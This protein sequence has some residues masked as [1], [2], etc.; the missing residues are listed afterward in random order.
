MSFQFDNEQLILTNIVS[1]SPAAKIPQWR[2]RMRNAWL[3]KI[4][5]IEVSTVAEVKAALLTLSQQPHPTCLLTFSHPEIKHGLANDGI[6]QLNV[7]QLNTRNMFHG[8]FMP[9]D[10]LAQPSAKSVETAMSIIL[11]QNQ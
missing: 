2:S 11:L 10:A 1:C 3:Y 9:K 7:D 4:G 5:D 8:F 6:P